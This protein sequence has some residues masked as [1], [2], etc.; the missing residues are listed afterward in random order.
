MK[1]NSYL[2][3]YIDHCTKYVQPNK[4]E[5]LIEIYN[6]TKE[7]CKTI[8][9]NDLRKFIMAWVKDAIEEESFTIGPIFDREIASFTKSNDD[10]YN[11]MSRKPIGFDDYLEEAA[12]RDYILSLYDRFPHELNILLTMNL[13]IDSYR[14]TTRQEFINSECLFLK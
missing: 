14:P 4:L 12:I 5:H 9:D 8:T 3:Y 10:E 11:P 7:R 13:E 6:S 2:D 1:F